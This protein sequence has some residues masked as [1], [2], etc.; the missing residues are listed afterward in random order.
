MNKILLSVSVVVIIVL[1]VLLVGT[2][3]QNNQPTLGSVD[4]GGEYQGTTTS[5]GRFPTT[6]TLKTGNGALGSVVITGAAA[7]VINIYDATTSNV[8]ART[9]NTPTSTIYLASIPASA[10][11]GTYTFDRVFFTGLVVDIAGTMPTTTITY[12]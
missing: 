6:V 2:G 1:A 4:Y 12:R 8:L 5:T 3:M 10:A 11:A 9:G 7:G